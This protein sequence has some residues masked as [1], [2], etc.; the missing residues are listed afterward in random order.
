M[1]IPELQPLQEKS[2]TNWLADPAGLNSQNLLGLEAIDQ[3]LRDAFLIDAKSDW[4]TA[5]VLCVAALIE[6]GLRPMLP[7]EGTGVWEWTERFNGYEGGDDTPLG[8]GE[9]AIGSWVAFG[10]SGGAEDLRFGT[11]LP[12]TPAKVRDGDDSCG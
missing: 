4:Y 8:I 11:A 12:S 9:G 3:Q 1:A 2:F 6:R 7:N 5:I 10:D